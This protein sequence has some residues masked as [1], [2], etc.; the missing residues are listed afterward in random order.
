MFYDNFTSQVSSD[1]VSHS[2]WGTASLL[3]SQTGL[4]HPVDVSN[5]LRIATGTIL[6]VM[7]IALM[8]L[9][10]RTPGDHAL[11]MWNIAGCMV[12]VFP[13]SHLAYSVL[14]LPI[15]WVWGA[16]VLD[17]AKRSPTTWIVFG[18]CLA[19][20]L[21]Q[22]HS[23]PDDQFNSADSVWLYSMVFGL[24]FVLCTVS[25]LGNWFIH[26]HGANGE[27]LDGSVEPD[28]RTAPAFVDA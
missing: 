27:N 1:L 19:Y 18:V 4:T 12:L 8:L 21:L 3:F 9:A 20:W 23:W 25:I 13:K 6:T 7:V 24:N 26:R 17:R 15:V 16:R 10:L 22:T 14:L 5:T 2:S 28:L 11:C